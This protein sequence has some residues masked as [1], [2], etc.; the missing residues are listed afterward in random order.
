V[1]S[2]HGERSW[3]GWGATGEEASGQ[4]SEALVARVATLLPGHDLTDHLPP[5]PRSLDIPVSR[6]TPPALLTGLCSSDPVDRLA[7]ARGKAFRDVVRNLHGDVAH[8][9]DIVARP[10]DEQDV[11]DVLDWC[12][13]ASIAV[14]PYGG[15]S[16][17]VGGVE[18]RFD[19]AAVTIDLERLDRVVEIDRTSRAARIQAG[20]YG[21]RL[22]EQLRP[23]GLTP[24][25]TRPT[26][27]R[28]R[29][30]RPSCACRITEMRSCGGP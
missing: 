24:A 22:E 11:I 7:H 15:G 6:V 19:R 26:R 12:A 21:P 8:I 3:W 16:S 28:A 29:G 18:P 17:V 10:R 5:D 1:T 14:I 30:A 25:T 4:E 20:T 2:A 27:R 9:P 13:R 23:A